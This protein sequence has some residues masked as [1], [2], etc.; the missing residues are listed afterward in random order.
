MTF[1]DLKKKH[2]S[3]IAGF[4]PT[5]DIPYDLVLWRDNFSPHGNAT[6]VTRRSVQ[7]QQEDMDE[8]NHKLEPPQLKKVYVSI[9]NSLAAYYTK[10][11]RADRH[12]TLSQGTPQWGRMFVTN[13]T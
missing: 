7:Q 10:R 8:Y 11:S 9:T 13:V 4:A 3:F 2:L 1:I 12:H 5:F 6:I